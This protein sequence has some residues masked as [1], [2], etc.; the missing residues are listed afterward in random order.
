MADSRDITGKNRVFTGTEAITLPSGTTAQRNGSPTGGDIRFNSTNNLAE[1]YDGTGWKSI[2]SPPVLST[3]AIDGGSDVT[4][5]LVDTSGGGTFSIVLKGSSFDTT[6]SQVTFI[7]NTGTTVNTQSITRTNANQHTVTVTKSDFLNSEEP[8]DAKIINSSGLA[9]TLA[10]SISVDTAPTFDTAAGSLGTT[11]VGSTI[12]GSTYDASA[13]DA[14]GDTI[15]YSI[16]A[17]S[18]PGG[19]SLSSSTGLITGTVSGSTGTFTFTVSA[20]TTD[21]T[22]TR[23]FSI[24]VGSIPSGGTISTSGGYRYHLFNSSG[25]FVVGANP[26]SSTVD[27]LV[28]GGGGAGSI[29][30]SGGAGAGGLIIK[31]GHPISAQ[32]YTV[33]VGGGATVTSNSNSDDSYR[34]AGASGSNSSA[35]GLTALGGG[36][37]WPWSGGDIRNGVPGGSGGAPSVS[38]PGQVG[39]GQQPSQSGDSGTYG[40]GNNSGG[41]GGSGGGAA[42][43]GGGTASTGGAGKQ[44]SEFSQFGQGGYYA[45]G[46]GGGDSGSGPGG[47]GGGG[48]NVSQGQGYPPSTGNAQS[49]TGGG[50]S[51]CQDNTTGGNGG[52]GVCIIRYPFS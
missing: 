52:S 10:D 25:S 43:V 9:A 16:S 34:Q 23:E 3:I 38:S 1:Y 7:S 30:H 48:G 51:G 19:L 2:D 4:T 40:F 15:T 8:Y 41:G 46:G 20:A 12:S 29:Q 24:T 11:Y 44:I 42:G 5:A 18:L 49:N 26:V 47:I 45:G 35:L 28:V 32:T 31:T 36:G 37:G 22:A 33:T 27:V 6:A 14:E 50:G 21:A 39:F 13:T 17:G